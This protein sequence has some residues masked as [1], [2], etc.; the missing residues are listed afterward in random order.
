[1]SGSTRQGHSRRR[2]VSALAIIVVVNVALSLLTSCAG[3]RPGSHSPT[4]AAHQKIASFDGGQLR[5]TRSY[6]VPGGRYYFLFSPADHHRPLP[7]VVVLHGLHESPASIASDTRFT[8]LASANGFAVVYGV[9]QQRAWNAGACCHQAKTDDVTY[10]ERVVADAVRR[11]D[12]DR[13][14]VYVVGFSNGAMMALRALCERPDIFAGAGVVS[15]ALATACRP[16]PGVRARP[17][18]IRQFHGSADTTL[19]TAGGY[20][21]ELRFQVPPL[22]RERGQLP[23]QTDL[24][25]TIIP[26]LGH[27]WPTPGNSRV[28]GSLEIYQSLSRYHL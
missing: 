27:Y 28:N 16:Q 1:M 7:L 13:R 9:G 2:G 23:P 3:S 17:L 22:S 26:G 25:V 5:Q 19:P 8:S 14:R 4:P 20:N 15:G 6:G 24:V 21:S 10:L 12:I 11:V 18:H